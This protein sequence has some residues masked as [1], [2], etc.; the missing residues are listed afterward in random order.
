MDH[1][2]GRTSNEAPF[3]SPRPPLQ[4]PAPESPHTDLDT[5]AC[6]CAP[7]ALSL[8][9]VHDVGLC[10]CG[11]CSCLRGGAVATFSMVTFSIVL[12]GAGAREGDPGG[13][14]TKAFARAF[15]LAT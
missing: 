10:C 4:A 13:D 12:L 8:E 7:R 11:P 3:P 2:P 1:S 9:T 5:I 15:K 6:A 14:G